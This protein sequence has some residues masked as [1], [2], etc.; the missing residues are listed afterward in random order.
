MVGNATFGLNS[1][2]SQVEAIGYFV[3]YATS[4]NKGNSVG[5]VLVM[6]IPFSDGAERLDQ[7]SLT[8]ARP[9]KE[10]RLRRELQRQAA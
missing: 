3:E 8:Q 2:D 7:Q 5:Q 9:I 4:V 1:A 10:E 6:E